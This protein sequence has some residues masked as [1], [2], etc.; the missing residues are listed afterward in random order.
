ELGQ[1]ERTD[2][3][4]QAARGER[5]GAPMDVP[6]RDGDVESDE[7]RQEREVLAE[8]DQRVGL[9]REA[10]PQTLTQTFGR[11]EGV[12]QRGDGAGAADHQEGEQRAP[13]Q[14]QGIPL[15]PDRDWPAA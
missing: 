6:R 12:V 5:G 14:E 4:A 3:I 15:A 13:E 7:D 8:L 2:R 1:V 9:T 11:K 10:V